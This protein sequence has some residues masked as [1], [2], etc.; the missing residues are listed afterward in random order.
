MTDSKNTLSS[1][2]FR[3]D[4]GGSGPRATRVGTENAFGSRTLLSVMA[5]PAQGRWWPPR[6]PQGS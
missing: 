1:S 3:P 2:Y 6:A 5:P 4:A